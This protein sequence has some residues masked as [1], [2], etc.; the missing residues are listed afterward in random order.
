M[1]VSRVLYRCGAYASHRCLSFIY[2]ASYPAAPAF[3]PPSQ[4]SVTGNSR[5]SGRRP[6]SMVYANLQP[7]A[8]TAR[9]SP[10]GRWSLTP[11]SHPY[12]PSVDDRR[13][14]SSTVTCRRRQL[15]FSPVERLM[16]PGLSSCTP[17]GAPATSRHTA[18]AGAKV[19]KIAERAKP[20]CIF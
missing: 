7:P 19:G 6:S 17:E 8:G 15:V 18:N 14:F 3:Y 4:P 1:S 13:L 2:T 11:P 10:G 16:L 12:L 9:R 5:Q 20:E